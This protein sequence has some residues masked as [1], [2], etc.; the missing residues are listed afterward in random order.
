MMVSHYLNTA[1]TLFA[2]LMVTVQVVALP[3]Q[4]PDQL[5]NFLPE[6]GFAVRTTVIS[7]KKLALALEHEVPQ[8]MP[9][10]ELETVP[11]R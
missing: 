2:A 8:L 5:L 6:L 7:F 9:G 1:V 3:V 4:T 10:G 11:Y